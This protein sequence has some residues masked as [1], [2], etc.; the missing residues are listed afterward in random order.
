MN[1]SKN[2]L[3]IGGSRGLGRAL[4]L[5]FLEAGNRVWATGRSPEPLRA[6]EAES[7]G[8]ITAL[9]SD[10]RRPGDN[11]ALAARL[12]EEAQGL[13]VVVVNASILGPRVTL[14]EYPLEAFDDVLAINLRG[15]FD[16]V[17]R[18][19]PLLRPGASLQFVTSGVG[20]VGKAKWG[21]YSISKFALEGMGQ[22]FA[23]ELKAQGVR[24]HIIDPGSM[25]TAM[26]AEAYPEE[27]P[28][29]LKDPTDNVSPF[30]WLAAHAPLSSSGQRFKAQ[31]FSPPSA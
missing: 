5:A 12:R 21:A 13:D 8:H 15:P 23:E 14:A 24:V 7:E 30:L 16:L 4:S 29:A 20:V 17:R 11:A 26:R 2:V 10:L 25:A 31:A 19:V 3:I 1:A 18:L 22:I 6:L 28:S 9:E 27:D